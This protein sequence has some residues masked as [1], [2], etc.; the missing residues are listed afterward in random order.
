VTVSAPATAGGNTF[1]QW[2]LDGT[3]LSSNLTETVVMLENHEMIAVY[4]PAVSPEERT[5]VV[6]SRNPNSGVP[7]DVS[8]TDNN[9]Y[10]NGDTVFVRIYDFGDSVTLVAPTQGGTNDTTF[11]YWELGGTRYSDE[12]TIT[13]EMLSD[14]HVTAVY[15]EV[16]GD[17]VLTVNAENSDT[18]DPIGGVVVSVAPTDLNGETTGATVF[19]RTYEQGT[20]ATLTAPA[21]AEGDVFQYWEREGTPVSTNQTVNVE[22]LTDVSM[23]AVYGTPLVVEELTL[24]VRSEGP[25]G[26]LST[27]IPDVTQDNNADASGTTSFG[28]FYNTGTEVSIRAP[29]TSDSFVF[30]HWEVDGTRVTNDQLLELTLL[31][32]VTV[33]AVYVEAPPSASGL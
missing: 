14:L 5:L 17:V 2:I 30:D 11:L 4:G 33:T 7:I 22:L 28:R 24:T 20:T 10:D 15:G 9:G 21:T 23:T 1:Q 8:L 27:L 19:Q 29:G 16:V 3:P 31:S 25:D 12:R 26:P 13:L 18:G 6:D 32:H